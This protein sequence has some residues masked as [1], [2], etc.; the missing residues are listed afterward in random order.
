[1]GAVEP[2]ISKRLSFLSTFHHVDTLCHVFD[3]NTLDWLDL[4]PVLVMAR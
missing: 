3:S 1:M 2:P 4:E